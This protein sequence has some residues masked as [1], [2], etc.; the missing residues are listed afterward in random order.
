MTSIIHGDSNNIVNVNY[1]QTM[2]PLYPHATLT[3]LPGGGHGFEGQ[4]ELDALAYTY[5]FIMNHIVE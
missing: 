4:N 1:V 3:V 5:A 2:A